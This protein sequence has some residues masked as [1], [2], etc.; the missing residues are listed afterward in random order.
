MT[1]FELPLDDWPGVSFPPLSFFDESSDSQTSNQTPPHPSLHFDIDS[2][3]IN[4][5]FPV[6]LSSI[7]GVPQAVAACEPPRRDTSPKRSSR[8]SSSGA[9]NSS[10]SD[11][12][13]SKKSKGA[14]SQRDPIPGGEAATLARE[15]ILTISSGEFEQF[16]EDLRKSKSLSPVEEKELKRQRRLVRNREY[17]QE[18][19]NKKRDTESQLETRIS[20]LETENRN[21]QQ[22]LKAVKTEN[23]CLKEQIGSSQSRQGWDLG[24][25]AQTTFT[26]FTVLFA[27]GILF[28][29]GNVLAPVSSTH[30][31]H[32]GRSLLTVE[33]PEANWLQYLLDFFVPSSAFPDQ[34]LNLHEQVMNCLQKSCI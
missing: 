27:F 10:D 23:A 32:T 21:L 20:A 33:T 13:P 5:K 12:T 3:N 17:A 26:L 7:P 18:S 8:K 2:M 30:T 16:A 14:S 28:S 34:C 1:T 24:I 15:T 31:F 9:G 11:S 6:D 19:R 25:P 22:E 4:F 29:L